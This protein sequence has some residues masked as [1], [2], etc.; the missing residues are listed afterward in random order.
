MKY[1]IQK[2]MIGT[3]FL[4]FTISTVH[5]IPIMYTFYE[6]PHHSI[7]TGDL[8]SGYYIFESSTPFVDPYSGS[9]SP[10]YGQGNYDNP[11]LEMGFSYKGV[12]GVFNTC[13]SP[14]CSSITMVNVAEEHYD[15]TA[16]LLD[17]SGT[18]SASLTLSSPD[19]F[20][21][22]VL[23]TNIDFLTAFTDHRITSPNGDIGSISL[24]FDALDG[25]TYSDTSYSWLLGRVPTAVPEPSTFVLMFGGMILLSLFG[26]N[27]LLK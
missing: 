14:S 24:S 12:T 22:S 17:A 25:M 4:L 21:D 3:V 1:L 2:L 10:G 8:F 13:L 20:N 9:Y 5:A 19:L 27:K 18:R 7:P 11:I 6:Q 16:T 26:K 23:T 15:L